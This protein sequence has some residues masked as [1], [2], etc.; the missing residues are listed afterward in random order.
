MP[1]LLANEALAAAAP[2]SIAHAVRPL[3]AASHSRYF[4][5]R[6]AYTAVRLPLAEHYG[7]L[8]VDRMSMAMSVEARSPMQDYRFVEM[9]MQLPL[10]YK[11]RNGDCKR[12]LKDAVRDLVPGDVLR[13]P[14]WGFNPPASEW[15]RTTLL[16]LVQQVLTPERVAEAGFFRPEA[17][18]RLVHEHVVERKYELWTVWTALVFHLWYGLYIDRSITLDHKLAPADLYAP[19]LVK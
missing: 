16:P 8:R 17:V 10:E 18:A 5:D 12:V 2:A 13:R 15:L 9:A 3:L 1:E 11:L 4:A 14:K 7:N 19:A 6:M